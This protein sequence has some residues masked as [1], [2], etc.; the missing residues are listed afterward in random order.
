[1]TNIECGHVKKSVAGKLDH[2]GWEISP[3]DQ[4]P[5]LASKS[6]IWSCI[7]SWKNAIVA[8]KPLIV[9]VVA[10]NVKTKKE[11]C[12]DITAFLC[13]KASAVYYL[14]S[15][16][17]PPVPRKTFTGWKSYY[18][19]SVEAQ[20]K[21]PISKLYSCNKSCVIWVTYLEH[22]SPLC[23]SLLPLI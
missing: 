13:G 3:E 16:W 17:T 9:F 20:N 14:C 19:V 5:E 12:I 1:M 7:H 11:I 2:I 4:H 8:K 22:T 21:V 15:S 23:P 18:H 6:C 10:S